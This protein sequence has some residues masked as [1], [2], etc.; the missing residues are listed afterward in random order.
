[1]SFGSPDGAELHHVGEHSGSD[2]LRQEGLG[3]RAESHPSRGLTG[4]G[5]LQNR[6][7]VV[8][9]VLLHPSEVCV[10]GAR[11]SQWRVARD[12]GQL[13]LVHG[14]RRHDD[15]PLGPFAVGHLD[16]HRAA[17]GL[18]VAYAAQDPDHV[19]LELHAGATS[20]AQPA[21]CEVGI[22]VRSAHLDTGGE[23][24]H[25]RDEGRTV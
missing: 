18:A 20:H 21:S 6:A 17:E 4:A 1:M 3:D 24:L 9:R 19:L 11:S 7:S 15:V 25:H 23:A 22:D 16:G 10:S 5:S 12:P 2:R 14:V 8:E 13:V